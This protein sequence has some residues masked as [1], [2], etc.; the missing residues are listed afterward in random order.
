MSPSLCPVLWL[1]LSLGLC[2]WPLRKQRTGC[3]SCIRPPSHWLF[4][5]LPH[6]HDTCN[7][8]HITITMTP[9]LPWEACYH[10]PAPFS[11]APCVSL[12]DTHSSLTAG[13]LP[14]SSLQS[15]CW[16]FWTPP[17]KYLPL[18]LTSPSLV[19]S[20]ASS[21]EWRPQMKPKFSFFPS[22]LRLPCGCL[23]LIQAQWFNIIHEPFFYTQP[24]IWS[25]WYHLQGSGWSNDGQCWD[26]R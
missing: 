14:H 17:P 22:Y 2:S 25:Y 9:S 21:P 5:I 4:S 26:G 12:P 16:N 20:V 13:T 24:T 23:L 6:L 8:V 11:A 7:S 10:L 15:S 1:S 19:G 18:T 3:V